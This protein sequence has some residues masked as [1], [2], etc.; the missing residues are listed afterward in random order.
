LFS[1]VDEPIVCIY[2]LLEKW[3]SKNLTISINTSLISKNFQEKKSFLKGVIC[4]E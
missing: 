3:N 2:S 1:G 4:F